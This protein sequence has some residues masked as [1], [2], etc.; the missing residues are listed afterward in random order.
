LP[1][2]EGAT[3]KWHAIE[4]HHPEPWKPP[5]DEVLQESG[6]ALLALGNVPVIY[7]PFRLAGMA[8]NVGIGEVEPL[9]VNMHK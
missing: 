1:C 4:P 6:G 8:K 5:N 7:D 9:S 3:I 2:G